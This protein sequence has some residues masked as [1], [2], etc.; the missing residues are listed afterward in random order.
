MPE[1]FLV[2][3]IGPATNDERN[4][5]AHLMASS[6]P[7]LTL[8]RSFDDCLARCQRPEYTLLVA[9][10]DMEPAGFILL[11]PDGVAGSPYIAT[12]ATSAALRGQGIGT[13]LLIHAEGAFPQARHIFLCVS[14]FNTAAQKLYLR[15]G[16]SI[17]GEFKDYVIQGAS[18]ILMIKRIA[19]E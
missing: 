14:S 4:W 15:N 8:G 1:L 2:T 18:E 6:D 3:T 13:A 7:W 9:R 10:R 17:V 16:Y 11:H 12:I 19:H 5:C